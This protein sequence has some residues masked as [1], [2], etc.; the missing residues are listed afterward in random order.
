MSISIDVSGLDNFKAK[1]AAAPE[2]IRVGLDAAVHEIADKILATAKG[3]IKTRTGW[4]AGS[5]YVNPVGMGGTASYTVGFGASY[6][7]FVE[8]G[9]KPHM[10]YPRA[11]G[12]VLR[13]ETGGQIVFSRYVHHPGTWPQNYLGG[14]VQYHKDE[15]LRVIREKVADWIEWSKQ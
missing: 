15:L 1:L 14:A 11:A 7:R 2:K 13:F 12:G 5:G 4:L 6:A 8:Y 3:L 9:T 10:I